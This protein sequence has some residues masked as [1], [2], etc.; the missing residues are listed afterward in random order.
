MDDVDLLEEFAFAF[1]VEE[2]DLI[3]VLRLEEEPDLVVL[4]VLLAEDLEDREED[5]L[6]EDFLGVDDFLE[7]TLELF[8]LEAVGEVAVSA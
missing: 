1:G 5:D 4:V 2:L 8:G 3:G 6:E 7:E